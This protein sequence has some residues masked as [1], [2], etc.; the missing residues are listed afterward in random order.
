MILGAEIAL[1]LRVAGLAAGVAAGIIA[2]Y[3][4]RVTPPQMEL[5]T[6]NRPGWWWA[7]A[8]A[9]GAGFGWFA[10]EVGE[11]WLLPAVVVFGGVTLALTLIDLD[12]QLIPNRVLF[13]GMALAAA[14]LVGGAVG[15]GSGGELV[16]GLIAA[17]VYFVL[18]LAVA[19]VARGG[20]GMG[21]VKLALL[22]GLFLGFV[23]WNALTVGFVLAVLLGGVASVLV[24]LFTEK[25]RDSKFAYGPY[26][27][28]GAWIGLFWGIQLWDWYLGNG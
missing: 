12:H 11:W 9:V 4:A 19:L 27:V 26:L 23:G 8:V 7:T 16:R 22:L 21:D 5:A 18:L 24:L 13:P 1:S 2:V 14:L 25:G 15:A 6:R 17:G 10:G 28:A 3:L 20:L